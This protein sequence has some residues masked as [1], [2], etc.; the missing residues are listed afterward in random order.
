MT[1][2]FST[3]S[4][5]RRN[6]PFNKLKTDKKQNSLKTEIAIVLQWVQNLGGESRI[7]IM[8]ALLAFRAKDD[9]ALGESYS[10]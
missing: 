9:W 3:Y 8:L 1:T 2:N 4:F 6:F 7:W 5:Q 10:S